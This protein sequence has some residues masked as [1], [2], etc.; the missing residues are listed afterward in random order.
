MKVTPQT[1]TGAHKLSLLLVGFMALKF[2]LQYL[3]LHPD[4]ELQRDEYLYLDQGNHLAWGFM[5]VPPALSVLAHVTQWLG[6]NIFWVKFWPA[7]FGALTVLVV[8]KIV[9]LLGGGWWA[10]SLASTCFIFSAYLRLNLL[11]QPNSLDV[12]AWTV[13]FYFILCYI[14]HNQGKYLILFG[15]FT[16]IG[17]SNKYTA[18]FLLI[19]TLGALL[20]TPERKIYGRKEFYL[21]GM[22]AFGLILPNIYWQYQHHFPFFQHMQELKETQLEHVKLSEFLADQII[23]CISAILVWPVGLSA[24]FFSGWGK[25]YRLVGFIFLLVMFMFIYLQGKS[26]YTLGLYPVL[27]ATGSVFWERITKSGWQT[28]LRPVLLIIP[29]CI[30]IPVIPILFPILSPEATAAYA[31]KFKNLGILRW[32]DGK[33]H[34][35]PQDFADMLGWRELT[36]KVQQ[37]YLLLPEEERSHTLILCDNYGQ[38]G[39]IN[40]YAGPNLPK[41]HSREASYLLWMPH[42]LTFK[43]LILVGDIPDAEDQKHFKKIQTTG[44]VTSSLAREKGTTILLLLNADAIIVAKV[45]QQLQQEKAKF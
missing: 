37:T 23:L 20:F 24:L 41:A 29:I 33:D 7:L 12:L 30:I 39:A 6:N 19:G 42:P 15:L 38:A 40:Y 35:L 18:G 1:T 5:E 14:Q 28:W 9:Q 26:Y 22:L 2:G 21:A 32:E 8:G 27:I 3:F 13:C 4:F 31:G 34:D 16:G 17:L 36:Y 43:N 44:T 25:P 11:F 10:L 45:N